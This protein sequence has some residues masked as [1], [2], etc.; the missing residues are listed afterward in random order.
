VRRKYDRSNYKIHG[1]KFEE[2][3]GCISIPPI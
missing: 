3:P 2:P 1:V